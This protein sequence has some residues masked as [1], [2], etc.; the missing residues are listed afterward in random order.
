[1][2]IEDE[3]EELTYGINEKYVSSNIILVG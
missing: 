3:N 1:M 2:G